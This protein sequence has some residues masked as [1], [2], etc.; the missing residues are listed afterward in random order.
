MRAESPIE[1]MSKSFYFKILWMIPQ[2]CWFYKQIWGE[3]VYN[4]TKAKPTTSESCNL[5]WKQARFAFLLFPRKCQLSK[6]YGNH[7]AKLSSKFPCCFSTVNKRKSHFAEKGERRERENLERFQNPRHAWKLIRSANVYTSYD[8]LI[9]SSFPNAPLSLLR[10]SLLSRSKFRWKR[11]FGSLRCL[12]LCVYLGEFSSL[13][14]DE[15][16]FVL[17]S[18]PHFLPS[19]H[20]HDG[21]WSTQK[22]EIAL[23]RI[24]HPNMPICPLCVFPVAIRMRWSSR[25]QIGIRNRWHIEALT[26]GITN[27]FI[28]SHP[29]NFRARHRHHCWMACN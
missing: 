29:V 13:N 16:L 25:K 24:F 6:S 27:Q 20:T 2:F 21:Y 3:S 5:E 23:Q 8:F 4:S 28:L 7:F 11:I 1:V 19:A 9:Q 26:M 12:A 10:C 18:S 14:D 15:F 22:S 17:R